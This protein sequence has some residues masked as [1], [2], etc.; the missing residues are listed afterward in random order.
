MIRLYTFLEL[1]SALRA[2][3]A[4]VQQP[5]PSQVKSSQAKRCTKGPRAAAKEPKSLATKWYPTRPFPV[6]VFPRSLQNAPN[7][8]CEPETGAAWYSGTRLVPLNIPSITARWSNQ[9]LS[10]H[11]RSASVLPALIALRPLPSWSRGSWWVC[12]CRS[13]RALSVQVLDL[14]SSVQIHRSQGEM[15]AVS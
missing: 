15:R 1:Y 6:R 14:G 8:R 11:I 5:I 3:V 10:C 7:V 13:C 12:C 4:D 2:H 9:L